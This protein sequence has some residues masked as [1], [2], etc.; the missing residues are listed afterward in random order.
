MT[1]ET[2]IGDGVYASF[3][4][5]QIKLR[6]ARE[7]GDVEIYLESNVFDALVEFGKQ[8]WKDSSK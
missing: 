8:C 7:D 2:Y 5:Y 6:T 3:D 1:K 4:G